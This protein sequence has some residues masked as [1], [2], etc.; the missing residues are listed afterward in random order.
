[1]KKNFGNKPTSICRKP[2][3]QPDMAI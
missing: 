2:P 3:N 1:M